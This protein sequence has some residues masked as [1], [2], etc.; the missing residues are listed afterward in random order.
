MRHFVIL[1]SLL[2]PMVLRAGNKT[3][4]TA[5]EAY[6][7]VL[8]AK[9]FAFGAAGVAGSISATEKAFDII[10]KEPDAAAQFAKILSSGTA[11]GQLYA[12]YGLKKTDEAAY[13]AALGI[14]KKSDVK[15]LEVSGC[16]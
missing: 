15:V 2:L 1:V 7:L 13:E 12:L 8:K 11:A 14:L 9:S 5:A 3:P 4:P 6:Q 10:L 16:E